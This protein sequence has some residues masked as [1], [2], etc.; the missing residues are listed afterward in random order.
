MLVTAVCKD[1][2]VD[3]TVIQN[4]VLLN[5][6]E[7]HIESNP[8]LAAL[9]SKPFRTLNP[10]QWSQGQRKYDVF[11]WTTDREIDQTMVIWLS[12]NVSQFD[13]PLK[14][15]SAKARKEG[16]DARLYMSAMGEELG[17]EEVRPKFI[18][19]RLP[20]GQQIGFMVAVFEGHLHHRE[21]SVPT[22]VPAENI[23]QVAAVPVEQPVEVLATTE[24]VPH[25]RS[26]EDL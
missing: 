21:S 10:N 6:I 4:F 2:F 3:P 1:G 9:R 12:P 17:A 22:E 26:M 15:Q 20:N 16:D 8:E 5:A 19:I 11:A 25:S 13:R 14:K 24:P 18:A 7:D 23:H